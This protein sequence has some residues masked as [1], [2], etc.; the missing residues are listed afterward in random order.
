[1]IAQARQTRQPRGGQV[2]QVLLYRVGQPTPGHR[3]GL[4][5]GTDDD[6]HRPVLEVEPPVTERPACGL[7]LQPICGF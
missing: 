6:V 1:M 2:T 3:V 4:A 7:H 5:V